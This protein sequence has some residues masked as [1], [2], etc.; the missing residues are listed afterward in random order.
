MTGLDFTICG[1]IYALGVLLMGWAITSGDEA[2]AYNPDIL[3]HARVAAIALGP[4][5]V[6]L[7]AVLVVYGLLT[8][9][10]PSE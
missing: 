5:S 3:N 10:D 8:G 1:L 4:I 6:A 2:G 9:E 7:V